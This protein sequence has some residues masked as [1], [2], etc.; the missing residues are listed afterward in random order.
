[1]SRT[2][3]RVENLAKR[4]RLGVLSHRSLRKEIQSGWARLRGEEDPNSC[5]T[6][7]D[8]A[9]PDRDEIL[10]ALRDVSFEVSEGEV[11]GIIGRNGAGKSTLLKIL[12][13]VT[14]PTEGVVRLKGHVAS[15]LEVGT[16]FH[17]ELTGRENIFLNGAILGMRQ[18]EIER[19]FD[20]IVAFAEVERFVDTP[21]KR[22]SSG[23]YVR[24][25]FSVAAHLDP[26]I[27]IVDE[28]LAVG[29]IQ[30]QR[31]CLGKMGTVAKSGRTVLFVSHN[32]AAVR[33]LCTRAL[34]FEGGRKKYEGPVEEG[35][36]SYE[37]SF[38]SRE[39]LAVDARFSGPLTEQIKF[40][41]LT[42]RQGGVSVTLIDPMCEFEIE[43]EGLVLRPYSSLTINLNFFSEGFHVT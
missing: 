19:K 36:A 31:K 20:E 43:L 30:F 15:L 16:G 34:L 23:M 21:V 3:I 32:L 5:V 12:S 24:L 6:G 37:R 41:R 10:W 4:Y 26:D 8:G 35:L 29:D 33:N 27:L 11:V 9:K 22:Y 38:S 42:Y 7:E 14:T 18:G 1:M 13:R 25:A 17:P 2:V 39:G 40:T 28:V